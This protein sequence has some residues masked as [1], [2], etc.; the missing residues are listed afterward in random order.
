M[1]S[2]TFVIGTSDDFSSLGELADYVE[3]MGYAGSKNYSLYEF[4][5]DGECSPENV[6]MIG[7]GMAFSNDWCID[8]TLSFVVDGNVSSFHTAQQE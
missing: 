5:I 3:K 7:R 6:T 8:D 4:N 2:Y 1:K